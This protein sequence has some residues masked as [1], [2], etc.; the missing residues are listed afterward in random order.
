MDCK[1]LNTVIK[2]AIKAA[3]RDG[4]DQ[5]VYRD[6]QEYAVARDYPLNGVKKKDVIGQVIA[7][8][9]RGGIL[10]A[11]YKNYKNMKKT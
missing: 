3:K 11:H 8:W 5:I 4:Y 10:H 6:G 2:N 1:S 7:E 9:R